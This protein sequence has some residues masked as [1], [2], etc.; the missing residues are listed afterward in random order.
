MPE[1][2]DFS[3]VASIQ[4]LWLMARAH[5]VGVGWVSILEPAEVIRVL[6]APASWKLIAYLCLGHPQ[7]AAQTPEL[8]REGL[9]Q[10]DRPQ[11]HRAGAVT[12]AKRAVRTR[13]WP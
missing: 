2:L 4:T 11:G 6:Q 10:A 13:P 5:G 12:R 8:E 3:V 9:G 7:A 1:S